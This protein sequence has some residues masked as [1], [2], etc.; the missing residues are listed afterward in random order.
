[1]VRFISVL[2]VTLALVG[3]VKAQS[4]VDA[5]E[6]PA[7]ISEAVRSAR[8]NQLAAERILFAADQAIDAGAVIVS[9]VKNDRLVHIELKR[10]A[11]G[12]PGARAII[13]IGGNGQLLHDSY[14]YPVAPLDLSDRTYFKE[15]LTGSDLVVAKQ[16][17]GRTSGASFVPLVKRLGSLTFVVVASPFALVDL[18]SECGDCWSLAL[19]SDGTIVTM[20]PP[21]AQV[22][23]NLINVAVNADEAAGSRVVRY[24]NSVVAVA[25]RKSPDFP[26][27][28]LSVRGLPDTAA[29]DVDI[30]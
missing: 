30:N 11:S 19:Q 12:V 28:N 16:V 1:M 10:L 21:E 15:A 9:S 6:V 14:K 5:G 27:I 25:W 26:L 3:S 17:V 4:N 7:L 22:S 29:V 8:T 13:V 2:V 20:F 23:P 24:K 18:Q